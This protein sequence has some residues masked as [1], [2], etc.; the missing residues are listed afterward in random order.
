MPRFTI[1]PSAVDAGDLFDLNFQ[2]PAGQAYYFDVYE[3]GMLLANASQYY[4]IISS[5]VDTYSVPGEERHTFTV[6]SPSPFGFYQ[7]YGSYGF[8]HE[9]RLTSGS[10]QAS[11]TIDVDGRNS[12]TP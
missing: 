5:S 3:G 11:A 6:K 9:F 10:I 12:I 7:T 4:S 8:T 1:N 2:I